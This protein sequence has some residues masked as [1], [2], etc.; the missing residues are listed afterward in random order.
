MSVMKEFL[1]SSYLSG[2]NAPFIEELYEAWL[3]DPQSVPQQWREY[4][5]RLQ[6]VPAGP[7]G[8]GA[9]RDVAHAPV[10]AAFA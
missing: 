10:V 4:F 9:G 6:A 8:N 3:G 7:G 2:S 5:D 1:S